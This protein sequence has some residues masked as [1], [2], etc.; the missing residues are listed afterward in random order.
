MPI[1]VHST[2]ASSLRVQVIS[3]GGS[4]YPVIFIGYLLHHFTIFSENN[5]YFLPR[6]LYRVPFTLHFP[7]IDTE[8]EFLV[9]KSHFAEFGPNRVRFVSTNS[10][11]FFVLQLIFFQTQ[12]GD[13]VGFI[14]FI[15]VFCR[16]AAFST[17]LD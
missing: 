13:F 5:P 15:S 6:P 8:N 2:R 16:T 17:N 10:P 14:G 7:H 12:Q 3:D 9:L 4:Y 11:S 1:H